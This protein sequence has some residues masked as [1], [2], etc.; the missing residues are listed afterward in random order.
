MR[1][2]RHAHGLGLAEALLC[3]SLIMA[4]A[5]QA[6]SSMAGLFD[7]VHVNAA[8][9]ALRAAIQ[10]ARLH[11]MQRAQRTDIVPVVDDDWQQG[12][13]VL[14]DANNNQR[15]DPGETVLHAGFR[16]AAALQVSAE[17][18]DGKRAYLAFGAGGRPRTASSALQ[19]Q[20]GHFIFRHGSERRK[21]VLGFLGRVRSCD[22][23][24]D[25]AAC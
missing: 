10:A 5:T 18:T 19:S 14:V 11:A 25:G 2:R 7:R 6:T 20:F 9:G 21:L 4:L 13:V 1:A 12:W 17:L 15:A 16:P 23:D 3:V 22:P 8:V 24:R